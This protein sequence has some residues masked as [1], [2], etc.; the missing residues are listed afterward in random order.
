MF[1]GMALMNPISF[2]LL[3]TLTPQ[4]QSGL[5]PGG[6]NALKNRIIES[7]LNQAKFH[8]EKKNSPR[9]C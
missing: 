5:Q 6:C 1:A 3:V 7:S 8:T 4:Y 9:V 2:L